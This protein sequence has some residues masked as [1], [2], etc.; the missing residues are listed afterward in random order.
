M[1]ANP[2]DF[3]LTPPPVDPLPFERLLRDP[4]VDP[5]KLEKFMALWERMQKLEAI[6]AFNEAFSAMQGELPT[7][8]E[9]GRAVVPS[10]RTGTTHSYTYARQ[11]DIIEIVRPILTKHGFSIRWRHV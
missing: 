6:K 10:Q 5:A 8:D 3:A 7:I 2:D 4:N 9:Q 1:N 11:E